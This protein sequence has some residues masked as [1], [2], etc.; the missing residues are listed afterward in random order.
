MDN[1]IGKGSR[2]S[3]LNKQNSKVIKKEKEFFLPPKVSDTSK[4]YY[5]LCDI[6]K[7]KKEIVDRMIVENKLYQ[8]NRNNC[9]FVGGVLRYNSKSYNVAVFARFICV[10]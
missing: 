5:F 7:I 10:S 2:Y 9:V 8:D 1:I 6:R 4:V 3:S